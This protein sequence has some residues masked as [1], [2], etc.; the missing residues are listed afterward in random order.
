MHIRALTVTD[1]AAYRDLR[2]RMLRD[3]PSAFTS[4]LDED[5]Q[6]PLSWT[7]KRIVAGHDSPHDLV[8]GAFA[9]SGDLVGAVGLAVE[10]RAKVRHKARLFGMYVAQEASS[11]GVGRALLEYCVERASA[12]PGLE[13]INLTVTSTNERAVR[14]YAAAGFETFGLEKRAI[15]VDGTYYSKTHMVLYLDGWPSTQR[16]H[17]VFYPHG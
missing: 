10:L 7:E 8:L 12:I 17:A 1:A 5:S 9:D 4:S 13:Q 16:M 14:L 15:K 3:H 2:L 6:K 11:N